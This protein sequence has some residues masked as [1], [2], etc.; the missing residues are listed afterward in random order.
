M[1]VPKKPP[2][3][4]N[5]SDRQFGQ[6]AFY[7]GTL[8][9]WFIAFGVGFPALILSQHDLYVKVVAGKSAWPTALILVGVGLQ[10]TGATLNK[11]TNWAWYAKEDTEASGTAKTLRVIA[12]WIWI[13]VS[14]DV[15][16]LAA[17]G[18]GVL[19]ATHRLMAV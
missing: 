14:I 4:A 7:N 12:Q 13:D 6:Y 16:T 18:T 19:V 17:L 5:D 1:A 8:R 2:S 11:W 10:V 15:V 9:A 3:D